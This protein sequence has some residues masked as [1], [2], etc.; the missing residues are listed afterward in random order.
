MVPE[1]FLEIL[2]LSR[3]KISRKTFGTRIHISALQ[4]GADTKLSQANPFSKLN[5]KIRK[6]ALTVYKHKT[7]GADLKF[8]KGGKVSGLNAAES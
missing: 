6:N 3:R 2:P 4:R 8:L 5:R 7:V 1:V